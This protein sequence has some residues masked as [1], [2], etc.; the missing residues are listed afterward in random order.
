M[1]EMVRF[2]V[3]CPVCGTEHLATVPATIV[4]ALLAENNSLRTLAG[5]DRLAG[6]MAAAVRCSSDQRNLA[7]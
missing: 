7:K 6:Y 2:L 4:A 5:I 3:V 1:G